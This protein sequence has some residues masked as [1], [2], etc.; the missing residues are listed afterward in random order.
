MGKMIWFALSALI[1]LMEM[2]C[3]HQHP[4]NDAPAQQEEAA[5][6]PEMATPKA[7]EVLETHATF[8]QLTPQVRGHI[9]QLYANYLSVKDA[10]V[11][12]DAV[13]ASEASKQLS[14]QDKNFDYSW[15]P[16]A[17]K[18][19]YDAIAKPLRPLLKQMAATTDIKR[20][21]QYFEGIS[22][23]FYLLAKAFGGQPLYYE[24]C[25]MAF[26]DKGAYWISASDSIVNPYFGDEMLRCGKVVEVIR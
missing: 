6:P 10:L 14:I 15:F 25:P 13:S 11:I 2:G 5:T 9:G 21:R 7:G 16:A 24:Y 17:Q 22:Q 3:G 20:Q 19:A 4:V 12:G 18:A 26:N 8:G 23:Q 1:L